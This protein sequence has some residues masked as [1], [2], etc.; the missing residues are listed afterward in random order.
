MFMVKYMFLD[1]HFVFI[2][3]VVV[4]KKTIPIR[5]ENQEN[6]LQVRLYPSS[7][8]KYPPTKIP[9]AFPTPKYPEPKSPCKM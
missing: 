2:F 3:L 4:V 5:R 1:V 7:P 8:A 6:S 9:T